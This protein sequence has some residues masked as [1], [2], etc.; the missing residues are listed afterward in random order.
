MIIEII[1]VGFIYK[2]RYLIFY[3][4]YVIF[5]YIFIISFYYRDI[6]RIATYIECN[7]RMKYDFSGAISQ[8]LVSFR[9][10]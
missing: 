2:N 1:Y 5:N 9:I 6:Y 3:Y 7:N 4:S 8:K 10:Q